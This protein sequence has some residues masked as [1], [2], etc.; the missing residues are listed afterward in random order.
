MHLLCSQ[1]NTGAG[2][3]YHVQQFRVQGLGK[4]MRSIGA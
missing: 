4:A 3:P 1:W 2:W